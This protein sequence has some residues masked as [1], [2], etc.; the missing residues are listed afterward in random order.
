M[1]LNTLKTIWFEKKNVVIP[2]GPNRKPYIIGFLSC[3]TKAPVC[4][5]KS[6]WEVIINQALS[7]SPSRG[8]RSLPETQKKELAQTPVLISCADQWNLLLLFF[9]SVATPCQGTPDHKA[10]GTSFLD[11]ALLVKEKK[12]PSSSSS[13]WSLLSRWLFFPSNLPFG[14]KQQDAF[15]TSSSP[16]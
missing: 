16:P 13:P 3:F 2:P 14:V 15:L 10:L 8:Q 7:S 5:F 4:F 1:L 12:G 11:S 9:F 6:V